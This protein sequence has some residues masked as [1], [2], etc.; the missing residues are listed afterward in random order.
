M[1]PSP[2]TRLQSELRRC[3]KAHGEFE[4][5]ELLIPD[6]NAILKGKRI[7]QDDFAKVCKDGFFFCGGTT[8]LT[9]LGETVAGI[10]FGQDDGD[11]DVLAELVPG[12]VAP[13][14]WARR[15]T[16]QALFRMYEKPGVPMFSDP[17]HVLERAMRPLQKMGITMVMATEL[18]FYLLD[19]SADRPTVAGPRVPGVDR[20]QPGAQVYH[21][22]DLWEIEPF[23]NDVYDFCAAQNIPAD[24]AISEY[25]AGQFEINLRH[26]DDPVLACDHAV[27]LKR[28]VKAAARKHGFV[29]CFMAK[30]FEEDAGSGLHVHMSLVDRSGKN[31][32]SQGKDSL[33]VPPFSARLRHAVGG[34]LKT[35]PEATAICAPNANSYRRLRPDMFA[36]VEPNW[37]V[38]HRVVAVRIPQSD[39]RNLRFEHR[40]AGADAN[41]YLVTAAI[42]ASVHYGLKNKCDPGTMVEQ[43][44]HIVPK[45]KIPNRWDTAIDRLQRSKILP[46]YLGKDYC[47][48]FAMN[49]R[50]ESRLF[51]NRISGLDFAWYLRSA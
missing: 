3:Q 16:G 48:Y 8:L 21:P 1:A 11:P 47:K 10:P 19:A 39:A 27:L 40:A 26:I 23:V 15:P 36:P 12:S 41:P 45:L 9:A 17:R 38:N 14:P 28:A 37:G 43:G 22:D 33:A 7:R 35:M 32:F 42:V 51:H 30:P 13:V 49:R 6:L 20:L 2:S 29:A 4:S 46:Q 18:E 24:A 44:A 5:L 31:Y 25:S 50:E 34:L